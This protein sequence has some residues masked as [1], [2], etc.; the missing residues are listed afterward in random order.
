MPATPAN[1]PFP[2]GSAFDPIAIGDV[3]GCLDP[4][5]RLLTRL[6]QD[7]GE[8]A[9]LWFTGDILNRGP[10]SLETLRR[11]IG[12]GQRAVTVLGNHEIHL[13]GVAAGVRRIK[14]GDTLDDILAAP[15]CDA[16]IDWVRR[17]PLA[18]HD[19]ARLMVHAG[20]LPQWDIEE[21]LRCADALHAGFAGAHWQD[22]ARAVLQPA[23]ADWSEARD[24]IGRLRLALAALTRL[25][26]C[27]P[28]GRPDWIAKGGPGAAPSGTVPWFDVPGRRSAG[29]PIVFGHWA[30][31]G[32]MVRDDAICLDSGCVWGNALSA[33][34]LDRAR[35]SWQERAAPIGSP[36]AEP[37]TPSAAAIAARAMPDKARRS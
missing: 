11:I 4:L 13:L 25:R 16:L 37:S 23:P 29:I 2:A 18:V 22:F 1:S 34:R 10:R 8:A 32:L 20:V 36:Q 24:E 27:T 7:G 17:Q 31:L 5:E 15:D 30:A 33:M 26:F 6:A 12:L 28:Q 3:H 14:P 21:V 35:Q 19:G 9:P